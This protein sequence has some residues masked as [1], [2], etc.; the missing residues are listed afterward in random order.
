MEQND[1]TFLKNCS[2]Q[3]NCVVSSVNKREYHVDSHNSLLMYIPDND[4]NWEVAWVFVD[5]SI[6]DHYY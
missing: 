1:P 2:H 3:Y 6:I 5:Q 4:E